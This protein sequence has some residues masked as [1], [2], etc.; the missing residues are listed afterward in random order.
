MGK[1][2]QQCKKDVL[3]TGTWPRYY[4]C[5]RW[6]VADGYCRQHSPEAVEARRQKSKACAPKFRDALRMIADG[7]PNAAKLAQNTLKKAE[8]WEARDDG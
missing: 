7:H 8:L 4:R 6:A 2:R 5:E 3:A 1:E